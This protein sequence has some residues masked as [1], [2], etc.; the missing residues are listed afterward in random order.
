MQFSVLDRYLKNYSR[1]EGW[2]WPD[3]I[4]IW[5]SLLSFQKSAGVAGHFLEIGVYLGKSAVLST[6]HSR[7]NEAC[8]LVDAIIQKDLRPTIDSIKPSNVI[9]AQMRSTDMLHSGA[10]AKHPANFRWIHIDGEHTGMAVINDL[11]IANTLLND[12]GVMIVDDF[13]NPQYPQITAAVFDWLR[14]HPIELTLFLIG[15]NKGYLCRPRST[16]SY[17]LYVKDS[18]FD[19]MVARDRPNV[20]IWKTT[21]AADMNT[22]GI[23]PRFGNFNYIGPDWNK[24]IIEI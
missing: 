10:L 4:A 14:V 1:L 8:I 19:D 21:R 15:D 9:Y 7:D 22:F 6:L 5:D 20:S 24:K 11:N 18:L 17:L 2:F 16:H 3:S 12:D 23:T 13:F